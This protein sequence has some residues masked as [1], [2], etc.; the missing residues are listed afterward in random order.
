METVT[1]NGLAG[2]TV[3]SMKKDAFT[4]ASA[5]MPLEERFRPIET[6]N[7]ISKKVRFC[8]PRHPPRR[9]QDQENRR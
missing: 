8:V 1:E 7:F 9:P 4:F 5:T 2:R 6:A 3:P